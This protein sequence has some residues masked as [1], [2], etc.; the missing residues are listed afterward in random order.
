MHL[1]S[2]KVSPIILA[3]TSLVFSR[4]TFSLINDPEGPNLLIVTALAAVIY[5]ISWIAYSRLT[6]LAGLKKLLIAISIQL[7]TALIALAGLSY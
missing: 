1:T 6:S 2:K 4:A 7:I 5:T 3:V